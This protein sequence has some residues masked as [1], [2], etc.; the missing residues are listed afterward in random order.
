MVF[1]D[2]RSA[3]VT[4]SKRA[5]SRTVKRRR[6]SSRTTAARRAAS[7]AASR[8][9]ERFVVGI[10]TSLDLSFRAHLHNRARNDK[11]SLNPSLPFLDDQ[12]LHGFDPAWMIVQARASAQHLAAGMLERFAGFVADLVQGFQAVGGEAGH[13]HKNPLNPGPGQLAE[14]ILGV[15]LEPFLPAEQRLE[16]LRPGTGQPAEPGQ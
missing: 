10:V 6:Q 7:L 3:S 15:R 1:C 8:Y 2:A 14:L 5:F 9:S 12:V 16:G 4:R 11:S 13:G